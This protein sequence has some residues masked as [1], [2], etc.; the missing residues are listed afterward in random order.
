MKLMK[1]QMAKSISCTIERLNFNRQRLLS[2]V[3]ADFIWGGWG[4]VVRAVVWLVLFGWGFCW[5]CL[6]LISLEVV[7]NTG[8]D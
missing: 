6:F 7:K 4:G 1:S 2:L 5:F 3:D 8:D